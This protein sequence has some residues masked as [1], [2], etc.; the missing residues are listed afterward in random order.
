[1]FQSGLTVHILL[2]RTFSLFRDSR[3]ASE[4][5]FDDREWVVIRGNAGLTWSDVL[6]KRVVAILREAGIGKTY[7]FQ[8]Q[9]AHLQQE[10]KAARTAGHFTACCDPPGRAH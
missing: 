8:H 10:D 7:E 4:D 2:N 5:D 3:E 1:M 6:K 9:A